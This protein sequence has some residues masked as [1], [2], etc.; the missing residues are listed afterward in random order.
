[1]RFTAERPT[2]GGGGTAHQWPRVGENPGGG[3]PKV[4]A[5]LV[6]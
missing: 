3:S 4:V 6:T 5:P 2:F 1:M